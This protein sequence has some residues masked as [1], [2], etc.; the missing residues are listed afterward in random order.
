KKYAPAQDVSK[1][2]DLLAK[3]NTKYA[4]EA[5]VREAKQEALDNSSGSAGGEAREKY[6]KAI[7]E[8][9]EKILKALEGYSGD[10]IYLNNFNQ[11]FEELKQKSLQD[12]MKRVKE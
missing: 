5:L 4:I 10:V 11:L 7:D 9:A 2:A 12:K 6:I 1:Y 8:R 3:I